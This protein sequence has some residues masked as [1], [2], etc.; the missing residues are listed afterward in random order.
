MM[1]L[2]SSTCGMLSRSCRQIRSFYTFEQGD[3]CMLRQLKSSKK[4]FVGPLEQAGTRSLRGGVVAHD[5][6][7]GKKTRS[8]LNTQ[9]ESFKYMAH[10]PT[11][12]E[13]VT[14]VPR[15]CTPIYPKDAATIVQMLDL[16]PGHSVLEA[17]TGNGS[18]TLYMARAVA[19]NSAGRIDTFDIRESHSNTAKKHVERYARGRY[20]P[21]VSFHI[22]AVA[23]QLPLLMEP[24]EQYDA[25][26]LDMPEPNDQIP[27][28]LPYLRNDRFIVCYLPNMTQV[29]TL[30]EKIL[31]L[32]LVMEACIEAEWKEWEVRATHIRSRQ[33]SE[34][35]KPDAWVCR[36]KNFDV[37]GHTAF[38]VKLRKSASA[39]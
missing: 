28:L 27:R 14:N 17:G 3:F 6:I 11:L 23:D 25:I 32:P 4:I 20:S 15:A 39:Q 2:K 34:E 26:A 38:L 10:F 24:K 22:G 13:Y 21:H 16:E 5:D 37:K 30:A 1:I 12:E 36:P 19:G 31:D 29:L 35:I 9:D 18:L 8:I 7:I 33:P